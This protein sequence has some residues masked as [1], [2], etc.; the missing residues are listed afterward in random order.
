MNIK[1][2]LKR[3][4]LYLLMELYVPFKNKHLVKTNGCFWKSETKSWCCPLKTTLMNLECLIQ[5]HNKESIVFVKKWVNKNKDNKKKYPNYRDVDKKLTKYA[6]PFTEEEIRNLI[7]VY[8]YK[9]VNINELCD[10]ID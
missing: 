7:T 8:E 5:Y 1:F 9:P 10:F 6:I 4:G 3:K 2:T